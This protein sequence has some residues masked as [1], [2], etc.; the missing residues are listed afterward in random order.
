MIPLEITQMIYKNYFINVLQ[1]IKNIKCFTT[2]FTNVDCTKKIK[3]SQTTTNG[4]FCVYCDYN[5]I[6]YY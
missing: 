6:S 5:T 3:C 2:I 4:A 1:Q